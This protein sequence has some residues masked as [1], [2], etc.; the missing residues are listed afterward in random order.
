MKWG[1]GE[2]YNIIKIG[3]KSSAKTGKNRF[4]FKNF[5]RMKP[6]IEIDLRFGFLRNTSKWF[7]LV[8]RPFS[9]QVPSS[10]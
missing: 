9:E 4:H 5:P 3:K 7:R 1:W 6:S 8:C 10:T 2:C